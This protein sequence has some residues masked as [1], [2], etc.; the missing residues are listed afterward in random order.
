MSKGFESVGENEVEVEASERAPEA[1]ENDV[2]PASAHRDRALPERGGDLVNPAAARTTAAGDDGML[3]NVGSTRARVVAQRAG[4]AQH[5]GTC[6]GFSCDLFH[7]RLLLC[8]LLVREVDG[9]T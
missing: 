9:Q 5:H 7:D 2:L 4:A 3:Q 6:D 8:L 1:V